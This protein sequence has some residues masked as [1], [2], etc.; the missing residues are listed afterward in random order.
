[1]PKQLATRLVDHAVC[2]CHEYRVRGVTWSPN[3]IVFKSCARLKNSE[4]SKGILG[5]LLSIG[6][7]IQAPT[8]SFYAI[9]NTA[10]ETVYFK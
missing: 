1:M 6:P 3:C 8:R 5:T 7:K 10:F 9:L 4:L 2:I